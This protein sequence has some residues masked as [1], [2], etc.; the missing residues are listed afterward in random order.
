MN[1]GGIAEQHAAPR[2]CGP[3]AGKA[4]GHQPHTYTPP[5]PCRIDGDRAKAEPSGIR[6]A[7]GNGRK[8]D[9]AHQLPCRFGDE[10]DGKRAR[11]TDGGDDLKDPKSQAW[12]FLRGLTPSAF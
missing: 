4:L 12:R 7:D 8:G 9:M 3:Q 6:A 1:L 2:T 10:R 11:F 5:L